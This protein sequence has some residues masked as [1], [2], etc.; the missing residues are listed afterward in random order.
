[1]QSIAVDGVWSSW[2]T[3]NK[4]DAAC[5]EGRQVAERFCDS[6]EPARGGKQCQGDSAYELDCQIRK[7][8]GDL[9]CHCILRHDTSMF[10]DVLEIIPQSSA[11]D[12]INEENTVQIFNVVAIRIIIFLVRA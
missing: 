9:D 3:D 11:A 12:G 2:V 8:I 1:M 6:P 7:C 5:G 4:C 10:L